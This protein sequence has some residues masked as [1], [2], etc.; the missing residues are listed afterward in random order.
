MRCHI[1]ESRKIPKDIIK[2]WENSGVNPEEH[3]Y[4]G[5]YCA[6]CP[7]S[8]PFYEDAYW[9]NCLFEAIKH[10]I[11]DPKNVKVYKKGSWREIFSGRWPHFYFV[12]KDTRYH[13]KG[14]VRDLPFWKQVWF[15]G[16]VTCFFN[17]SKRASE[18]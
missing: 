12:S 9:S 18:K 15:K 10:K 5:T 17:E 4:C 11:K 8:D 3:M 1:D 14:M 16:Y 7:N 13:F 6:Y 2:R